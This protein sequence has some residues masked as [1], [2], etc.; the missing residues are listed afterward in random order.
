MRDIHDDM[1][2]AVKSTL[3]VRRV[4][5]VLLVLCAF[6]LYNGFEERFNHWISEYEAT[7]LDADA[8]AFSVVMLLY[9]SIGPLLVQFTWNRLLSYVVDL[10][11]ITFKQAIVLEACILVFSGCT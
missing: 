8:F 6:S 11:R 9:L 1:D 7:G 2:S 4:I 3:G 10:P 5:C